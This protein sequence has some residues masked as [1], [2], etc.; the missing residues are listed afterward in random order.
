MPTDGLSV[1][2]KILFGFLEENGQIT[3]HQAEVLLRCELSRR[4]EL[5]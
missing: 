5:V 1:Q 2:Q 3:S 4:N